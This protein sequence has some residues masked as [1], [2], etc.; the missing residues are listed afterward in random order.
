MPRPS[1]LQALDERQYVYL[2][3]LSPVQQQYAFLQSRSPRARL[4]KPSLDNIIERMSD[5]E[6]TRLRTR[7]C[8]YVTK[9]L[10][11]LKR[12]GHF[13]PIKTSGTQTDPFGAPTHGTV[14]T[15]TELSERARLSPIVPLA[16]V[17]VGLF[18]WRR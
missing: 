12:R 18:L 13:E 9:R 6:K 7:S 1:P 4:T 2:K 16:L 11:D 14:A 17:A 15:Q 8:R 3:T 10:A 5:N